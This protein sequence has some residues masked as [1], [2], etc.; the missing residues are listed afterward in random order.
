MSTD[1]KLSKVKLS[2]KGQ[3]REFPGVLLGKLAGR[4]IKISLLLAKDALVPLATIAAASGIDS[5]IQRK[6]HD[7]IIAKSSKGI[8]LAISNKGMDDVIR[9]IKLLE[10]WVNWLMVLVKQ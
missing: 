8:T 4:L 5:T 3:S 1:I 6:K 9:N 2:L 10:N 7:K